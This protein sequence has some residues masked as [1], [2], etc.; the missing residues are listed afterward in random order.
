M[1]KIL[2]ISTILL[3]SLSSCNQGKRVGAICED[4]WRSSATGQGACSHHDGVDH[5]LYEND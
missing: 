1:R 5:W 3:V 2:L 4:G